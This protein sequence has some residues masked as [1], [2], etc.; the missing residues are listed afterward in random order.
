MMSQ[1][2]PTPAPIL[3]A[4]E[5]VVLFDGTCKLCNGWAKFIINHDQKHRI[6]LAT[7]QSVEGQ[8]LLEWAGLPQEKFNTIVLIEND[9]FYVRSE[10]MFEIVSRLP[11][12]M[13]WLV[14]ARIVPG[15]FRDW[16]YDKIALNRYRL[17]G[18]YETSRS[19]EPDH[20]HRF[21]SA[22]QS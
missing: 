14:A 10:A 9:R 20:E 11:A 22:H 8:A 6:K 18:R 1:Q 15:P 21:L 7:V 4:G 2:R 13:K 12:P 17:F 5:I 3:Q 19:P 16:M